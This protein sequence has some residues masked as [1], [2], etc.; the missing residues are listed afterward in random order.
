[1][2]WF[3]GLLVYGILWWLVLFTVLPWGVRVPDNPEPGHAT[4]APERPM[5]W[6]KALVTSVIAGILWLIVYWIVTSDLISVRS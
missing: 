3:S 2:N 5:L 4:S 6:R 1:M